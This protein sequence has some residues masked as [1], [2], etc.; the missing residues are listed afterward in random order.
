MRFVREK[1]ALQLLM[2][3]CETTQTD[4][5]GHPRQGEAL[6]GDD[7]DPSRDQASASDDLS[8]DEELAEELQETEFDRVEVESE[9]F[10]SYR[11]LQRA[12]LEVGDIDR[13]L[14]SGIPRQV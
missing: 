10:I 3:T 8:S 2:C 9:E 5:T 1:S 7:A 4:K 13:M 6:D 12:F 11:N 14:I